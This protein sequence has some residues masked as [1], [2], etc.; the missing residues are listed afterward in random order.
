M[1]SKGQIDAAFCRIVHSR[2]PEN[3]FDF[4]GPYFYDSP[5]ILTIR[6]NIRNPADLK[7]HKIAAVQG[8]IGE[9]NAM[10]LLRQIG[11]DAPEKNVVS[12]PDRP[13]CFMAL[14]KE[15]VAGWLDSGMI[16]LEYAS[17]SPGRFELIPASDNL[18]EVVVAL[19]QDDSAWRDLVNFTIQDMIIDGTYQ[20]IYT[21]WFGPETP[22][23]FPLRRSIDTWPE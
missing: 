5:Q 10:K 12:F 11:D 18:V 15:K 19:P 23:S 8:S 14:G 9:R 6:G 1:L 17:R 4:S 22:Y 13:S 2:S 21:K 7:G 3:E 20:K 16:L